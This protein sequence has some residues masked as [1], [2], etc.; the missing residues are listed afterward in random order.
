MIT[1]QVEE[2][3]LLMRDMCLRLEAEVAKLRNL[4]S[5]ERGAGGA[6]PGHLPQAAAGGPGGRPGVAVGGAAAAGGFL[7]GFA[8]GGG[9][10]SGGGGGGGGARGVPRM[11]HMVCCHFPEYIH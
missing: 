5:V 1:C 7:S 4:L 6:S 10:G 2:D 8:G 11:S 9:G 3:N